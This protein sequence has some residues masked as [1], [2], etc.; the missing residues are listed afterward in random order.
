[1]E[2]AGQRREKR[3]RV[4]GCMNTCG[5]ERVGRWLATVRG[6]GKSDDEGHRGRLLHPREL[7]AARMHD[8]FHASNLRGGE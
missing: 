8:A 5:A 6:G 1:V 3:P 4:G 2:G 7:G